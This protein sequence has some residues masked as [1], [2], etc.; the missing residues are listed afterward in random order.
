MSDDFK[1]GKKV[2][3]RTFNGTKTAPEEPRSGEDYWKLIGA[4]GIIME[5]ANAR[6]RV[7]VQFDDSVAQHGLHCHNS[8]ANS[9]YILTSDLEL[10]RCA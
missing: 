1:L 6:G 3:L 5:S 9:L 4:T 8:I 7:L 10:I 2:L